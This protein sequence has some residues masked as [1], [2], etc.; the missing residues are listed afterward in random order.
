MSGLLV[1]VLGLFIIAALFR[2]DFFFYLLYL[3]FGVYLVSRVWTE[4]CLRHVTTQRI[5]ADR[6]FWGERIP[7]TLRVRNTGWLPIVYLR[8]RESLPYQLRTPSS[9]ASVLSLW[10]REQVNL[11]Y[12][13][14]CRARG[15]YALG[16]INIVSGDLFGIR[17]KEAE[18]QDVDHLTVYPRIV[19][20]SELG[21]P[22]QTP[23]GSLRSKQ[24]LYEDPTRLAGVREY[25]SGDS[26]RYIHWKTTAATGTLQVKRFEPAIS[27]EALI[28]LNLNRPE[29]TISRVSTASELAI[30]TAASFAS[31]LGTKR[32]AVGLG[33]NGVDPMQDDVSLIF[34]PPRRGQEQAM[35]ILDVLARVTLAEESPF[36]DLVRQAGLHLS[37]GG[38]IIVI[39]G[40][41]GDELFASMLTLQHAG[42]HVV[43]AVLDPQS[44]FLGIQQRAEAVGIAAYQIW[45]ESDLDVWR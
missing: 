8:L 12:E 39:T 32:Q 3:F 37:W 14:E 44:P 31:Y 21:L 4:R 41:A 6:A 29:Y 9:F 19:A 25:T 30:V 16:P 18:V 28:L 15:Y 35:R 34:L 11:H 43:L 45:Q 36:E 24:R 38:T 17:T 20:L 42:Y 22:A 10:P 40:H 13:L 33:C 1:F 7:V 26:L 23:F 5:Y 2:V 27:I